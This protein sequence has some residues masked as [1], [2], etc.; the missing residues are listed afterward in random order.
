[1]A[2]R[3]GVSFFLSVDGTETVVED[4]GTQSVYLLVMTQEDNI[5]AYRGMRDANHDI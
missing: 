1:M 4:R 3:F 2:E 5:R